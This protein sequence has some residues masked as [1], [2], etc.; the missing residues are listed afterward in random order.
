[1][2]LRVP[3]LVLTSVLPSPVCIDPLLSTTTILSGKAATESATAVQGLVGSPA[4][5]GS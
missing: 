2:D 4:R 3:L 5:R 1:M